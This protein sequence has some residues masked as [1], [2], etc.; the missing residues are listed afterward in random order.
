MPTKPPTLFDIRIE[1]LLSPEQVWTLDNVHLVNS[2]QR[3]L[4]QKSARNRH[5]PK[6]PVVVTVV[7][8]VPVTIGSATV[9]R[10]VV[11]RATT[12][13]SEVPAPFLLPLK[14]E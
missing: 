13:Q 7:R 5:N 1:S 6:P 9:V 4:T 14:H 12:K 10:I 11:E 8:R 3:V 2:H